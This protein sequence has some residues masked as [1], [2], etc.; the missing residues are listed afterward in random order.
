MAIGTR[1][2]ILCMLHD[3]DLPDSTRFIA[4]VHSVG[5]YSGLEAF[6]SVPLTCP[7]VFWALTL[8]ALVFA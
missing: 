3:P 6:L 1:P 7:T 5:F 4:F 8:V 2:Q